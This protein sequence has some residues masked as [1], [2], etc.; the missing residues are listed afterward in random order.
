MTPLKQLLSLPERGI[1]SVI[2]GGG[3]TSVIA[4]LT[5]EFCREG[6]TVLCTTTTHIAALHPVP[7]WVVLEE[8]DQ[9]LDFAQIRKLLTRYRVVTCAKNP[10]ILRNFRHPPINFSLR[11]KHLLTLYSSKRTEQDI[12]PL[13][14]L[15]N[16]NRLFSLIPS[17]SSA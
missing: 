9:A 1:I 8:E 11:Q 17:I 12:F 3:K 5:N 15:L 10:K 16:M 13:K 7:P 6:K 14:L 2:G 4:H